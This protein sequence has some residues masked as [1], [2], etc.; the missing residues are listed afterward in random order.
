M[1]PWIVY[2]IRTLEWSVAAVDR[3]DKVLSHVPGYGR[4]KARAFDTL[5]GPEEDL[6]YVSRTAPAS[7]PPTQ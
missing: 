2:V 3:T 7:P 4:A 1:E 6:E 5:L